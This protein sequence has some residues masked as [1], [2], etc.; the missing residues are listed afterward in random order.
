VATTSTSLRAVV[1][2]PLSRAT[3]R[4][5]VPPLAA[6]GSAMIDAPPGERPAARTKSTWPP[7]APM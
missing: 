1:T 6:L 7:T 3:M 4:D 5:S 2:G